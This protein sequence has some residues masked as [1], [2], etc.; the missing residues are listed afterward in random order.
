MDPA[1]RV[2]VEAALDSA[3]LAPVR[4]RRLEAEAGFT[5]DVA[6]VEAMTLTKV[7]TTS[8]R[9]ALLARGEGHGALGV[10]GEGRRARGEGRRAKGEG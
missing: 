5:V 9:W 6:D 2:E 8:T 10:K 3:Y 7:R 1:K 4:E